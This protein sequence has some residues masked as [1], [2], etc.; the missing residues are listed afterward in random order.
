MLRFIIR[1][2]VCGTISFPL[3]GQCLD[4]Q[5]IKL[6]VRPNELEFTFAFHSDYRIRRGA[7]PKIDKTLNFACWSVIIVI[8]F[9]AICE[10]AM[11]PIMFQ[12]CGP[13]TE[14]TA[15]IPKRRAKVTPQMAYAR[16]LPNIE[17]VV[18]FAR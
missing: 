14:R 2:Q 15:T 9:D 6:E 17:R 5:S 10:A 12:Q 13:L 8:A 7:A 4:T 1:K 3:S 11:S 16:R 18:I